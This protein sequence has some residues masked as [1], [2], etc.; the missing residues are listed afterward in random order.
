MDTG[1]NSEL[2]TKL[3]AA[4]RRKAGALHGC[5]LGALAHGGA[6]A[7]PRGALHGHAVLAAVAVVL[8]AAAA[9]VALHLLPAAD[10]LTVQPSLHLLYLTLLLL[11]VRAAEAAVLAGPIVDGGADVQGRAVHGVAVAGGHAQVAAVAV[12]AAAALARGP[13][14]LARTQ[15]RAVDGGGAAEA[16]AVAVLARA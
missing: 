11:T 13:A 3:L 2:N 15:R 7:G 4:T 12:V 9:R 6:V 10:G 5:H 1:Y 14:V 8:G 16:A